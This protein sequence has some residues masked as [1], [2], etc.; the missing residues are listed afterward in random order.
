[1]EVKNYIVGPIVG[2]V[3]NGIAKIFG[4]GSTI[5][6]PHLTY[7]YSVCRYRQV[8]GLWQTATIRFQQ[9]H[10]DFSVVTVLQELDAGERYEYQAGFVTT[11]IWL[12]N[13]DD[14]SLDWRNIEIY[15][16][17]T[18]AS[19]GLSPVKFAFGSCR[20]L[21][22]LLGGSW[23]DQRGDKVFEAILKEDIDQMIM[24]GDQI[25]ADDLNIIAPDTSFD[26]YLRR[27]REVFSQPH[28]STLVAN[29][30]TSMTLDDHEI[31][32]NWPKHASAN[33]RKYKY[34]AALQAYKIYQM[35]HSP[36]STVDTSKGKVAHIDNQFWYQFANGCCD[37]FVLDARTERT[38]Q[39]MIS[40]EQEQA[41]MNFLL[42]SQCV[43]KFVASSVPLAPDYLTDISDKWSGFDKQRR[44]I[45]D[46]IAV[47][48]I[49]NVVFISGDVH[50]AMACEITSDNDP[51]FKVY[52][53][54]SSPL[55]W[56]INSVRASQF[57]MDG[58]LIE[59]ADYRVN[60]LLS[61]INEDNYGVMEANERELVVTIKNRKHRFN[62][63]VI[64]I[65]NQ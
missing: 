64:L 20:Y 35:S 5:T 55:F 43:Y 62:K 42:K 36:C 47:H 24:L 34:P 37:F 12:N 25:Y 38:A 31:E 65:Q 11:N 53:V 54:V 21:L 49:P 41:L 52:S 29:V 17:K 2:D 8:N 26:E 28:F 6:Q 44:R 1:M 56:P 40:L 57:K 7:S 15:R 58:L 45:L 63:R 27:Y 61:P 39:L 50:A 19:D 9:P 33:D 18:Y 22:K 10:F 59:G 60:S 30:P 48:N 46:F 14:V 3:S 51:N 4:R 16:F 32:D 13:L 23:F